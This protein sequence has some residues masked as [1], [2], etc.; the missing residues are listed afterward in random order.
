MPCKR[1]TPLM[2]LA[3]LI[4]AGCSTPHR[5]QSEGAA[6]ASVLV[7]DG[8]CHAEQAQFAVGKPVTEALLDSAKSRSGAQTVRALKPS[9]AVTMDYRSERL[10][11][12]TDADG[13]VLRAN[14]G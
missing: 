4:L 7:D 12:N 8:R 10:N 11:L 2:I 6:P 13:T 1:A 9:D 14:C 3:G 5:A